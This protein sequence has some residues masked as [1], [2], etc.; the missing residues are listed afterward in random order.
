MRARRR[1]RGLRYALF[2]V[3]AER[4]EQLEHGVAVVVED[5]IADLE[6][7]LAADNILPHQRTRGTDES[8]LNHRL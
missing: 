4:Y 6:A 3:K 1:C 5:P 8:R 7:A 2:R